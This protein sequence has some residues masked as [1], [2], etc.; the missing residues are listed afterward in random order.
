MLQSAIIAFYRSA[1][2]HPLYAALNVLGLTVGIAVFIVISLFVRFETTYDQWVPNARRIYEITSKR[3]YHGIDIRPRPTTGV[4]MF[5]SLHASLPNLTGTRIISSYATVRSGFEFKEEVVKLVDSQF[6]SVFDLPLLAGDRATALRPD[7]I[8]LSR[9]MA[10]KYFGRTDIVG[11]RILLRNEGIDGSMPT[12][13]GRATAYMVGAVIAEEPK[14]SSLQLDFVRLIDPADKASADRWSSWAHL[15]G[16]TFVIFRSQAE[17]KAFNDNLDAYTDANAKYEGPVFEKSG[18][19]HSLIQYRANA[20]TAEHL[21][22]PKAL[23]AMVAFGF[24]GILA[25][26]VSLINYINL[27][28]ARSGLRAREVA[29]RKAMGATAAGLRLQILLESA[30]V[31]LVAAL[32]GFS[33]VELVLPVLNQ[34]T[35]LALQ[36]DYRRDAGL[37]L[38]VLG[39]VMLG[40][41]A[42]GLYPAWVV[43]AFEP[44]FVLSSSMSPAGGRLDS[45]VRKALSLFQFVFATTLFILVFGFVAQ[46]THMRESDLGFDRKGLLLTNSMI[47]PLLTAEQAATIEG[48]WR[49]LPN[50]VSISQGSAPGRF[51]MLARGSAVTKATTFVPVRFRIGAVSQDYFMV[52]NTRLLAGRFLAS[53]DRNESLYIDRLDPHHVI[54]ADINANAVQ[55]F[56]FGTAENAIGQIVKSDDNEFEIV[57]V[58]ENQRLDAPTA[59][60]PPVIYVYTAGLRQRTTTLLRF[61]DASEDEV[62]ANLSAIWRTIAPDVPLEILSLAEELDYYYAADQRNTRLFLVGAMACGIIGSIG[63]YGMAAF[64][65]SCRSVEIAL[66][67][68]SGAS[69][70]QV[71]RLLVFQFLKP[72]L[73][74]NLIAWPVSWLI[75]SRWLAQFDDRVVMSPAFFMAG[76]GVSLLIAIITVGGLAVAS[77][78][79]SP[80]KALRHE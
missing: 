79:A 24:T 67:K 5:E 47:T 68:T 71:A 37:L 59:T 25:F 78:S 80:G 46:V 62:K 76:S 7:T 6:F 23:N 9:A 65:T 41:L 70:W 51:L 26:A 58:V 64:S 20:L 53:A 29:V 60:L 3:L 15:W 34:A 74:A 35:G 30:I 31:S 28:T 61:R 44:A 36:L 48:R 42:A 57:G 27:A 54:R 2:R 8:I 73:L 45:L 43:S 38:A 17:V 50:V 13:A 4:G 21:W 49:S 11:R 55:A 69:K 72:V 77:A 12:Y 56:G 52:M 75:L 32:L 33:L 19:Y 18:P 10:L 40:S 66:R 63:L 14:N 16:R 39:A 1:A 22:D